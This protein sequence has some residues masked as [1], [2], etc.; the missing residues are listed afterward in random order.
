M[1]RAVR[2]EVRPKFKDETLDRL[3]RRFNKKVKKERIMEKVLNNRYYEKPSDKRR[4]ERRRRRK[5][6]EKLHRQRNTF[7]E[8]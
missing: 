1:S 7:K 3:I 5:V 6:I 8:P 2:V 4:K